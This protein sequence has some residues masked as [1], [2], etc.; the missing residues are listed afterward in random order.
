MMATVMFEPVM[1][2]IVLRSLLVSVTGTGGALTA[3][4]GIAC[5]DMMKSLLLK[6]SGRRCGDR[7][8][9][10][11]T[12]RRGDRRRFRN[13]RRLRD[14]RRGGDGICNRRDSCGRFRTG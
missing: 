1:R 13:G 5:T 12:R 3:P 11:Y 10:G 8:G 2:S 9:A 4:A 6:S 7:V 14:R